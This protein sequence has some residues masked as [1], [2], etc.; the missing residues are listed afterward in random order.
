MYQNV[1]AWNILE[2]NILCIRFDFRFGNCK[3]QF[4]WDVNDAQNI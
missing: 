4:F 3:L 1:A 2:T